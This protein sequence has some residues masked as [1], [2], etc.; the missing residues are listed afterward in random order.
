[1]I[2][3]I[4]SMVAIIKVRN[5]D[6]GITWA[7]LGTFWRVL[8]VLNLVVYEGMLTSLNSNNF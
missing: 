8:S 6:S 7:F 4:F 1:M 3:P 5:S 2:I